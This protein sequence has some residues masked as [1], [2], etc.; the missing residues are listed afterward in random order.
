[1]GLWPFPRHVGIYAEGRGFV[2]NSKAGSVQLTDRN[3]F[4]GD[5]PIRVI[6]R[7]ANTDM[8]ADQQEEAVQRAISL[9]GTPYDLLNFNCEHAAYYAVTGTPKSPQLNFALAALAAWG[10]WKLFKS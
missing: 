7:I 3:G 6:W 9:M 2:H 5:R 1:V 10:L 4:A 8:W